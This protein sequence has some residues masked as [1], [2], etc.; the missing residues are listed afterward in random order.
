MAFARS[1]AIRAAV[2]HRDWDEITPGLAP[3]ISIG[4]ASGMLG[5]P[6]TETAEEIYRRADRDLYIAKSR[7]AVPDVP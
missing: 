6:R 5:L 3:T 2:A 1:R 7:R 4:V